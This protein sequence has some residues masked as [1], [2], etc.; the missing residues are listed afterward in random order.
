MFR[1]GRL[2]KLY[3]L[4]KLGRLSRML[5]IIKEKNTII[6]YLQSILKS[7]V[8][9]ERFGFFCILILLMCHINAC[10]WVFIAKFN[11][12]SEKTW[13]SEFEYT[14][15]DNWTLW[16]V[17]IYYCLTTCTTVGYGDVFAVNQLERTVSC[18]LK[19]QSVI[20]FGIVSG[21][22]TSMISS[23]N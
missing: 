9:F 12:I 19:V 11:E 13:L 23:S 7:N 14:D 18:F 20:S 16:V 15:K 6:K 21:A 17:S 10:V 1:F 5:K 4:I 3:K 8:G 22:L 2:S